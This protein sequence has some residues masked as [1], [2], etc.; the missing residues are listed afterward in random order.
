[1]AK[2]IV[3]ASHSRSLLDQIVLAGTL[4][5]RHR[6]PGQLIADGQGSDVLSDIV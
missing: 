2:H 6:F 4:F 3:I 5:T 1:M